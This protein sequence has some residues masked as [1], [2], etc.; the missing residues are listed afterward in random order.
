MAFQMAKSRDPA[1]VG[2]GIVL[3]DFEEGGG[4]SL[5]IRAPDLLTILQS[6]AR[7]A[8]KRKRTLK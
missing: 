5:R 7:Q 6:R 8:L 4:R 2:Y 3:Y 1:G